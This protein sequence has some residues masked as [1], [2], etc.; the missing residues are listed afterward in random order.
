M[1][2]KRIMSI[3]SNIYHRPSCKYFDFMKPGNKEK[4][5]WED[6]KRCGRP[7]R[8]CNSMSFLCTEE[9]KTIEWNT[10]NRNMEFKYKDGM[11]Y[12]KTKVGCW[13][14]VYARNMEQ[15]A[16]YHRNSRQAELDFKHPEKD[17]YHQQKDQLYFN[18]IAQALNYIYDHDK[19]KAAVQRGDKRIVYKN[20]KY[21]EQAKRRER[22]AA[23]RRV[24]RLFD[25]IEKE[26][27]EKEQIMHG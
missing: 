25:M 27:L 24:D 8:H 15:I 2:T 26:R 9:R 13:K 10:E 1:S 23:L 6:A 4:L 7:C 12:V 16:L 18:N 5:L 22:K 19:Y 17:R 3:E 14:L 11:L 20:K 21:K